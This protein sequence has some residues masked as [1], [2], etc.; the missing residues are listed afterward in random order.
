MARVFNISAFLISVF[1][2]HYSDYSVGEAEVVVLAT[3][4]TIAGS[5]VNSTGSSYQS[6]TLPIDSLLGSVPEIHDLANITGEQVSQVGSQAMTMEIWLKLAR[7]VEYHLSRDSVSGVVV[8][9]GTDTMEE[10]AYFLDLVID[11]EK[12]V[13]LVGSMRPPTSISPDGA[14]NLY[15]AIALASSKKARNYGTMIVM[16]GQILAARDATKSNTLNVNAFVAPGKGPLGTIDLGCS[17][18]F[19]PP[20]RRSFHFD[21]SGVDSLPSTEIAYGYAGASP[22]AVS[23]FAEI[24]VKGIVYAGVGNGNLFPAVESALA[25]MRQLGVIVVRSSRVGSGRVIRNAEVDDDLLDFVVSGDLS[26]QKARVLLMLMLTKTD[27]AKEIQLRF[28]DS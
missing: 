9:H 28:Y 12:P 2:V 25:R 26:P 16:N 21:V 22:A 18:L 19:H 27:S 10:T 8:T 5:G 15:D 7:R 4:G 14:R 11:S 17:T 1:L 13:V 6:A 20:K 23:A 24:G 3:G